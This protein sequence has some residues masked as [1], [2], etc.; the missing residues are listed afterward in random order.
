MTPGSCP[1][2]VSTS[3]PQI[4]LQA[5]SHVGPGRPILSPAPVP[6]T[7]SLP[8][9]LGL[10][11]RSLEAAPFLGAFP[12]TCPAPSSHLSL[13]PWRPA[14]ASRVAV[15]TVLPRGEGEAAQAPTVRDEGMA[16]PRAQDGGTDPAL[17]GQ[18]LCLFSWIPSPP[19]ASHRTGN[20]RHS[21]ASQG[22]EP[23]RKPVLSQSF[24]NGFGFSSLCSRSFVGT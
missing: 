22:E 13:L 14:W 9:S 7:C 15:N 6:C 18:G 12:D 23:T 20:S 11:F 10:P 19:G 3:S 24:E 5:L 17:R 16:V 21:D 1:V 2:I 8:C 4:L